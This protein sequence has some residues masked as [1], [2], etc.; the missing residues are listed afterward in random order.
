MF[1]GRKKGQSVLEYG[2]LLALIL[3]AL[4]I[5]Q[6]YVKR[7]YQGRLKAESD[8]IGEDHYAPRHTTI[9][10][11]V[12]TN[13]NTTSYTGVD[14]ISGHSVPA[15]VTV[16]ATNSTTSSEQNESIDSFAAE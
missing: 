14:T 16:T 15:G 12:V 9:S 6:F 11:R 1:M 7:A 2:I 4:L 13:S 10:S 8:Q 3:A 5:M